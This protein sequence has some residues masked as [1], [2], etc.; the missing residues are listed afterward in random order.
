MNIYDISRKAGVSI[1]TVSRVMNNSDHVSPQTREKVL[2]VIEESGFVPNAFA[3]GLGLN[4]MRTIGLLCPDASDPYQANALGL[5]ENLFRE[6]GY[7]CLLQ[8]AQGEMSA[9]KEGLERLKNRHVDAMVLMGS[10]FIGEDEAENDYIREAAEL[11]PVALLNGEMDAPGVY[12]A[13]CDDESASKEAVSRLIGEGRTRIL[14]LY[15][16]VSPSAEKKLRG[17]R[18]ALET[19]GIGYDEQLVRLVGRGSRSIP[20]VME[21]LE[22]LQSG[23]VKFD[24]AF[25][26]EDILAVG[27]VKF[28]R[29]QGLKVPEDLAVIGYND[30]VYCRCCEP[31]LTSVDNRLEAL[32]EHIAGTLVSVLETGEGEKK[33]V[34]DGKLIVRGSTGKA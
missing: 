15:N 22:E 26:S 29:R 18:E 17:Y 32:C 16:A 14:H 8:C 20:K 31:E 9:R 24:A 7:D 5:M 6:Q 30:S 33:K 23:G 1:A 21:A 4:T 11:M 25:C 27:A 34:F 19:A 2:K 10:S 3:R 28:A 13:V 12:S